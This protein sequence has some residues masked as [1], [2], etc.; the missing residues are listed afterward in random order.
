MGDSSKE[1]TLSGVARRQALNARIQN[2]SQS[3][4]ESAKLRPR[5]IELVRLRIAFHNQCR[6][7]MSVRNGVA[8]DDG[9]T[10]AMVCS[11]EKPVDDPTLS[12]AEQAALAFADR[13]ANDHLAIDA[14]MLARLREHFDED[15]VM[16]LGALAASFVG[17]GRM[18][19]V[20]DGGETL[21]VGAKPADGSRLAPWNVREPLVVR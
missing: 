18:G 2:F 16:D 8:L 5:V 19:A 12:A 14:A 6:Y 1:R 9:L 20:F 3:L 21:P 15:E 7:C 13:F 10:E 4:R 17:F 11:L